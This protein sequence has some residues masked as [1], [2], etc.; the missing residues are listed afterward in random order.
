MVGTAVFDRT[1]TQWRRGLFKIESAD[2]DDK[3]EETI[4]ETVGYDKIKRDRLGK[5]TL[6]F[7]L[8]QKRQDDL[9]GTTV[10]DRS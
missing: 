9:I 8:K 4:D 10:F 3:I 5:A 6:T 7:N 2:G 1:N